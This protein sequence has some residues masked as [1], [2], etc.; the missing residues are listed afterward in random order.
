[1]WVQ[2]SA[3]A[4]LSLSPVVGLVPEY[5]YCQFLIAHFVWKVL[6]LIICHYKGFVS[7]VSI[8]IEKR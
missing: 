6:V 2:L 1:M 8:I 5:E 4:F 7:V 3:E